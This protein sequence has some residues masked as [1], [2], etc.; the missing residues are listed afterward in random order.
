MRRASGGLNDPINGRR[1]ALRMSN[2]R[3]R[4]EQQDS[5]LPAPA[6]ARTDHDAPRR[7]EI[8]GVLRRVSRLP[9]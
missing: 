4:G 8:A 3:D 2:Q 5:R 6:A 7:F 1:Y 9:F